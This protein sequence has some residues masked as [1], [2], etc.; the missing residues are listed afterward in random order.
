MAHIL[1]PEGI[2]GILGPMAFSPE[3]A[4]PFNAV[5]EVLLRG[6]NSLSAAEREMIATYVSSQNDCY[7]C[8]H[9]HG[10]VAAYRRNGNAQLVDSVKT[11][12]EVAA[13]SE[14]LKA[15]LAIAGKVERGGKQVTNE[16]IARARLQGA[17]D[18][19]ISRYCPDCRRVLHVQPLCKW[20]GHVGAHRRRFI[21]SEWKAPC[22]RRLRPVDRAL[23]CRAERVCLVFRER[24]RRPLGK[25]NLT[26]PEFSEGSL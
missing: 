13:I 10:A 4:K 23:A 16:D 11:N 17:T 19:E 6:P 22:R 9:A 8:Q 2:P 24:A 26:E 21:S 25:K 12:F 15:L 18:K 5:A 20:F 1:L 14:K 3:T 7:F